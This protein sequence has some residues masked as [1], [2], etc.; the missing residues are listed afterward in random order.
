M[1]EMR[2]CC[3]RRRPIAVVLSITTYNIQTKCQER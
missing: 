1:E 2:R 3:R